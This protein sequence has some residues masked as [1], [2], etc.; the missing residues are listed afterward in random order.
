MRYSFQRQWKNKLAYFILMEFG[1][2]FTPMTHPRSP[3]SHLYF[4]LLPWHIWAGKTQAFELQDPHCLPSPLFPISWPFGMV[5]RHAVATPG[6]LACIQ[7]ALADLS[8]QKH[9]RQLPNEKVCI[10]ISLFIVKFLL[11][12]KF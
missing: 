2:Y 9:S 4:I 7:H 1:W 6:S 3:L 11:P 8:L 10:Y 5:L 12:G